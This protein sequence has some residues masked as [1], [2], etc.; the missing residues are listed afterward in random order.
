MDLALSSTNLLFF[1]VA[2]IAVV[3]GVILFLKSGYNKNQN[4]IDALRDKHADDD[5]Q[6]ALKNRTKYPEAN[7]FA[8]SNTFLLAGIVS[9]LLLTLMA[10]SWSKFEETVYIP[11]GAMDLDEEI[12]VETPRTAEPPPPPPPPPPPVIEEVPEEEIEEEEE[13]EF[14]DQSIE[15][16]TE[17]VAP[18][19]PV[20]KAPPPPPPPPPPPAEEEIFQVVE[21]MPRFP[22][23]EDKPKAERAQCAQGEMLSYIYK[24]IKYPPLAREN[25]VEGTCVIRFVV[26]SKGK[27]KDYKIL[28]DI[29]AGCGQEALR[30]VKKMASEKTWIPGKQRGK[31][32]SVMFSLPVKFKLQG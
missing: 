7:V 10:F 16:E 8:W 12:E 11:E 27:I 13:I 24:H 20:K 29:G 31:P 18:P 17:V 5:K 1:L 32:V 28:R 22:G 3:V 6:L 4:R 21:D 23:C 19:E 2:F 26:D 25:G 15:E 14:Q 30:I 9:A